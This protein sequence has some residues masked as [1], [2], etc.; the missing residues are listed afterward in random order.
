[1]AR[2]AVTSAH[3]SGSASGVVGENIKVDY[4]KRTVL[5]VDRVELIAGQ[6]YALLGSSGAG[7]STLLR[8]LGLLE[9]PT[10]GT[11]LYDGRPVARNDLKARRRI[12]AVFQK[13]Y[14]L[15]GT[16]A[17]NAGYGLKLR[18]IGRA[19]RKQRVAEALATVGLAGWE[20]RSALTLSGGE[21]Q[22]VALARAIVLRPN[23][24]LLDEPLSYLDP[25]LKRELTREFA[26]ILAS[27]Q[28]TSLY[29][30]HDQDEAA[31]VADYIGVMRDGRIIAEG[32]PQ[33]V[34]SL[35]RDPWVASFL[36]TEPPFEGDVVSSGDGMLTIRCGEADIQA[37]GDMPVG[38]RVVVGI[39][40]EDVMLFEANVEIPRTSARNCVDA[41]VT[42]A[43]P[44]GI[45]VRVIA[46]SGGCR[47]AATVSR[48][49]SE[50]LGLAPG[51][52]V[53]M[54]FKADAVRVAPL[55]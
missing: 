40:P 35:S 54:L 34:L 16:V 10:T 43:L 6:T 51:S 29:V 26:E 20:K 55:G 47:F 3:V 7:K 46:E 42:T 28:V 27:A 30:T 11:V 8:V 36:G 52:R 38:T 17:E 12:A 14:L 41:T 39:R 50:T 1:M 49:S 48:S 25:L 2:D 53:T 32:E 45:S 44:T 21:A 37:I 23:L 33:N 15:R 18:G 5:Q 24:L 13:P 19:E 4:Q 31:V 22:R 9:P